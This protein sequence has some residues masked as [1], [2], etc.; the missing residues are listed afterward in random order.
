[1]KRTT[2]KRTKPRDITQVPRKELRV[3]DLP[4]RLPLPNEPGD[5]AEERLELLVEMIDRL[6]ERLV[7]G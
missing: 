2:S 4:P 7:T 6:P 3:E 1:M 5:S